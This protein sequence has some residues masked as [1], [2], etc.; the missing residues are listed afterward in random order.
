M[1]S[2][3]NS[4]EISTGLIYLAMTRKKSTKRRTSGQSGREESGTAYLNTVFVENLETEQRDQQRRQDQ[5]LKQVSGSG[6]DT[7][8]YISDHVNFK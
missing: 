5:D 4:S 1:T 8:S 6:Q 2:S 3:Q 7:K